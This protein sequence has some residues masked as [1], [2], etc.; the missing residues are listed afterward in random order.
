V[1]LHFPW[2]LSKCGYC[3]FFSVPTQSSANIAHERYAEQVIS[4]FER[5]IES[6]SPHRLTS[7]FLG[8]GTPSLWDSRAIASVISRITAGFATKSSEVEVTVECNPSSFDERVAA[9]L[10]DAGVNRVSLG[11]QSLDDERLRFLG[12]RHDRKG[13]LDALTLAIKSE[14]PNVSADLL[15]GLPGQTTAQEVAQVQAIAAMP[16][17]HLSVYALT[18]E[19]NTPFGRLKRQG[20]LPLVTDERVAEAFVAIDEALNA[21][22]FEHYEISNFA[23]PSARCL[24]NQQYW[25]GTDYLGLGAAAWGTVSIHGQYLRYRNP[26]PIEQYL[27]LDFTA[28]E[29]SP[30][31]LLPEGCVEQLETLDVTMRLQERILLGLRTR[32]GLDLAAL[33]AELGVPVLTETRQRAILRQVARGNLVQE[34]TRIYIEPRAWLLSDSTIVDVA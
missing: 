11:L 21:Q 3:D 20:T 17:S 26:A 34:G 27:A 15:F 12:R 30:F 7:I 18:I 16:V 8:G 29:V 19:D 13:A 2:C 24:H 22:G 33:S 5:R 31:A 10:R 1:Y 14:F 25:S 28:P 4:E 32:E 23:R 6:L 9:G